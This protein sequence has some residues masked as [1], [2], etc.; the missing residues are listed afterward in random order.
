MRKKVLFAVAVVATAIAARAA[1]SQ[2]ADDP[3]DPIRVA[4]DTHRL[5][6]ENKFVRVLDVHLPP[7]KIEP[8]HR[9]PH[10]M[11]VYFTDWDAKVTPDGGATEVHHRQAG[12]FAWNEATIHTVQNA[13]TTEGHILRIELKL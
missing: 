3:L 2:S 6:F 10:G 7:G 12:T 9:H 11:S 5:A 4:G 13:G 1:R 8:R